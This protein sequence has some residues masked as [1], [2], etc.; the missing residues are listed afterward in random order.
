MNQN[1][2][3]YF[4]VRLQDIFWFIFLLPGF[5]C[6][7]LFF[8]SLW[9]QRL[10]RIITFLVLGKNGRK[11]LFNVKHLKILPL[12]LIFKISN[13]SMLWGSKTSPLSEMYL[14]PSLCKLILNLSNTQLVKLSLFM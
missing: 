3:R 4:V 6:L 13:F 5:I 9:P 2:M 10:T 11:K 8:C 12:F 7:D 1:C 14:L